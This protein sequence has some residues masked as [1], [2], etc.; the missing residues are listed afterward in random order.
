MRQTNTS[1]LDLNLLRLFDAVYRLGSVSRAADVLAISQPA[2]SQALTR[3]RLHL[4]DALF[5]RA[6]GGVRPTP[7]AQRLATA[8][9]QAMGQLDAALGEH[10]NF[11]PAIWPMQLRLHLSDIGE[12]RF[13]PPL[14]AALSQQAP[15]ASVHSQPLPQADITAALD[16]G[17]IDFAIGFL[18]TVQ[19]TRRQVLLHDRYC[20]LLR[21]GHPLVQRRGVARAVSP[22]TLLQLQFVAVRS[23][24]ETLRILQ[25]LELQDR[26]RLTSS[27]FLALPDIVRRTD[28]CVVMPRNIALDFAAGGEH[29]VLETALPQGRFTVALHWSRRFEADPVHRWMRRLLLELFMSH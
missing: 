20:V 14:M 16:G 19:D 24:S 2:A 15:L 17:Q 25:Q 8:V 26:V 13:L 7:R 11:E 28:L 10:L 1:K 18:P 5:V 9:Q 12:A 3:L 27:H 4:G 29:A 22:A 23:H 6:P 21:A